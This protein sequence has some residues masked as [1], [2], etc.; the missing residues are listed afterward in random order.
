MSLI[1]RRN[2]GERA[3]V[4]LFSAP[5]VLEEFDA[6]ARKTWDYWP[7][8]TIENVMPTID[9]Y[10]EKGE[11]VVKAELPGI[12][13]EDLDVT[14]EGDKLTIKAEKQ[15][16]IAEETTLH[17]RERYY[18]QYFRSVTLPYPVLENGISATMENGVLELRFTKAEEA[19]AKKIEIKGQ[20]TKG[21]KRAKK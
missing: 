12:S 15:E 17:K 20:L 6:L 13:K 3:L 14:L 16:E 18:G 4:P 9:V 11:L 2:G 19:R 21:K 7:F 5:S 8:S 1:I 10:E